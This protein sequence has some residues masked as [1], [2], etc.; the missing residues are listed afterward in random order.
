MRNT[1]RLALFII[2]AVLF[3]FE[4][5]GQ[6]PPIK[7]LILE[8]EVRNS[9]FLNG[10]NIEI[11]FGLSFKSKVQYSLA[12]LNNLGEN[13]RLVEMNS[14]D[15]I[16]IADQ[17]EYSYVIITM[18]IEPKQDLAYGKYEIRGLFVDYH[19]IEMIWVKDA[20]EIEVL[21]PK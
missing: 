13:F 4:L 8:T 1:A 3:L 12:G 18:I 2:L 21:Q 5:H 17:K 19:F 20:R 10:Q 9:E 16:P 6:A 14:T 7:N 11:R 15:P